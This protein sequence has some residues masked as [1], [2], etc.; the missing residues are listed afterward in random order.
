MSTSSA[1]WRSVLPDEAFRERPMMSQ[2][3]LSAM[4]S[5]PGST[6]GEDGLAVVILVG[7]RPSSADGSETEVFSA[8]AGLASPAVGCPPHAPKMMVSAVKTPIT[9]DLALRVREEL[10][11][12]LGYFPDSLTVFLDVF[13]TP[14]GI[15]CPM[16]T[17]SR[18]KELD[19]HH[20]LVLCNVPAGT[21]F[22]DLKMG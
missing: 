15:V 21:T 22:R 9:Q 17:K 2:N 6:D 4:S 18:C 3:W 10:S 14:F 11:V 5:S 7:R 19:R 20:P 12:C 1:A 16:A 8:G 13:M